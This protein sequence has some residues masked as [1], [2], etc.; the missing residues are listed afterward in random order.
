MFP[1][2][3]TF[4]ELD[5]GK[6][7]V[8]LPYLLGKPG[9]TAD[10][11]R[12][13]AHGIN[14]RW[15]LRKWFE[16]PNGILQSQ[17]ILRKDLPH[18]E[19]ILEPFSVPC[20][21]ILRRVRHCQTLS[22][23]PRI[24]SKS[25][26]FHDV[27]DRIWSCLFFGGYGILSRWKTSSWYFAKNQNPKQHWLDH[28]IFLNSYIKKKHDCKRLRFKHHERMVLHYIGMIIIGVCPNKLK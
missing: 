2:Y 16:E 15:A 6:C 4:P 3:K 21:R 10:F 1:I 18:L 23:V 26:D 19:R 20:L 11:R 8:T 12:S 27:Y 14:W 25:F 17:D 9:S 22:D 13:S 28:P 7:Y 5:D 24:S